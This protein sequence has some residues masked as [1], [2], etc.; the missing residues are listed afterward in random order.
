MESIEKLLGSA[1]NDR[2]ALDILEEKI[3]D[4]AIAIDNEIQDLRD[5]IYYTHNAK[6]NNVISAYQVLDELH[7]ILG[8]IKQLH[9]DRGE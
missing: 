5:Q 3:R 8:L 4:Y 1:E 9:Y 6:T 2:E 7:G